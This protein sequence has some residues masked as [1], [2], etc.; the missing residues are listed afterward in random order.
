MKTLI[1]GLILVVLGL[2][3]TALPYHITMS[4]LLLIGF[5]CLCI[6]YFLAKKYHWAK[7][8]RMAI[9]MIAVATALVLAGSMALIAYEG[10][11]EWEKAEVAEYAVVLGAQIHGTSPS[12]TLRERL[13]QA[14]EL[15]QRNQDI[16]I[17]VSGGQGSD[18]IVTEASVM[19]NYLISQG[20]DP[21]RVLMEEE[22]HNTRE[23]LMYSKAIVEKQGIDSGNPVIITSEF[24]MARAKYIASTLE[25]D[26]VGISSQ[27]QTVVLKCNYYLREVFA[28]VKAWAQAH[29]T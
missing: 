13:N 8:I 4:G 6:L 5:G 9:P 26:A 12:R 16:V 24:H 10:R 2:I 7:W 22:S 25:M 27:T 14:V 3:V 18:E 19:G 17:V 11:C 23:N 28:F 21:S 15:S 29:I 1:L 20:V